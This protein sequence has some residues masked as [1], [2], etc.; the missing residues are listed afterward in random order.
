MSCNEQFQ[1]QKSFQAVQRALIQYSECITDYPNEDQ[2]KHQ[3]IFYQFGL[4]LS[5]QLATLRNLYI[6]KYNIDPVTGLPQQIISPCSRG[7][8]ELYPGILSGCV[9]WKSATS[10]SP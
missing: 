9:K 10:S 8:F 7:N 3:E 4:E 2:K 1:I 6:E 5:T